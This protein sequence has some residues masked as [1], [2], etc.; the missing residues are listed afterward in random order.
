MDDIGQL[1]LG[2]GEHEPDVPERLARLRAGVVAGDSPVGAHAV[3]TTDVD[4]PCWPIDADAW[5]NAGLLGNAA[6]RRR[7]TIVTAPDVTSHTS[8]ESCS[9]IRS[10]P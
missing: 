4:R 3:L 2:L 9:A 5:A 1:R 8:N 6:G 10:I 7:V